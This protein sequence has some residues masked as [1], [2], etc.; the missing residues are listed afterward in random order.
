MPLPVPLALCV[1]GVFCCSLL[2]LHL[3]WVATLHR[4]GRPTVLSGHAD[5]AATLLGLGGFLAVLWPAAATAGRVGFAGGLDSW[6]AVRDR[7]DRGLTAGP[8]LADGVAA[9]LI[10]LVAV[11]A[12]RRRDSLEVHHV[13]PAAV[14]EAIAVATAAAGLADTAVR[15]SVR[16]RANHAT[17]RVRRLEP[18]VAAELLRH[19][20]S[21][22]AAAP[23]PG[24]PAG[25]V[26]TAVAALLLGCTVG[27]FVYFFH[28][29][30]LI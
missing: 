26:Y 3:L 10:T 13:E 2:A 24:R 29:T 16:P 25:D 7:L 28:L 21:S 14:A 19:L 4:R 6:P 30:K 8:R 17:V 22:L 12:W 23:P 5:F 11:G 18:A 1:G 20:R 27:L 15:W 9:G